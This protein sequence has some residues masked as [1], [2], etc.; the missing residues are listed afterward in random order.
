MSLVSFVLPAYKSRFLNQAIDS[1]LSQ[2]YKNFE[3]VVVDDASPEN[4][5]DLVS[6]YQGQP[7][8]YYRN[9]QNI[10][11]KSLV[12]QWNHCINYAL[13]EYIVLAADDDVY[14][15]QFLEQCLALAKKYPDVELIRSGV[16]QIDEEGR[17]IGMDGVLPAHC[18]KY[19]FL[20]YWITATSFTCIGN[21]L[22]KASSLVQKKFIDF[23]FAYGA[24]AASTIMMAEKGVGN[25]AE[26]LF[27]FRLSSIHL[28]SSKKHLRPKLK[29]N[30]MLYEWLM[31]LNYAK[32]DNRIDAYC[33][34]RTRNDV[35]YAK[36]KYD[37]YNQVIKYLP[38]YKAYYIK[39]CTLISTK[40]KF[41]MLLRFWVDKFF[42]GT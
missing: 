37:Y 31:N 14:H 35:I 10:G 12:A 41:I 38:F 1:I 5:E 34:D 32:P 18:S 28:S 27:Q 23:P 30:T 20:Y 2:S 11:G 8:R 16:E 33:Y 7:I 42:R 36:C 6:A 13:G 29:A 22:F 26:M 40:D 4:L 24:D 15:P 25:T 17:L 21:Y 9:A 19:Q 39:D 3:L